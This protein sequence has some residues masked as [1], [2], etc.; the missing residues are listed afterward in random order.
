MQPPLP[1]NPSPEH[2]EE[3]GTS[4][5]AATAPTLKGYVKAAKL[6]A[7]FDEGA[8]GDG[9]DFPKVKPQ[10]IGVA[11]SDVDIDF[12]VPEWFDEVWIG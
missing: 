2:P 10:S 1:K 4:K 11:M 5:W 3:V 7:G 9:I 6:V 8:V 12:G